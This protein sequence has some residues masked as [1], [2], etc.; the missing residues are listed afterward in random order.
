MYKILDTYLPE[1][2]GTVNGY[3]FA[4]N[5]KELIDFLK[6]AFY[7]EE[8]NRSVNPKN[9]NLANVI[10]KIGSS[11]FMISQAREQFSNMRTAFYLFYD[12]AGNYW[13]VSTQTN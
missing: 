10:L 13:A 8:I 4:E 3:L 11:C 7:A 5:P 12:F 2:F 9:G 1:G 6:K